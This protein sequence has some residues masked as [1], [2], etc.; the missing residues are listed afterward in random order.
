MTSYPSGTA[1]ERFYEVL[2]G[3]DEERVC[4]DIS[5]AS[6]HEQPRNFLTHF[7]SLAASRTAD[8]LLDPRLVLA[9]LLG[10]LGAPS[11]MIGMLVPIREAEALFAATRDRREYS[12]TAGTK[13][14]M[15]SRQCRAGF[16][17]DRDGGRRTL[18]RGG[19]RGMDH[20]GGAC[21]A[22]A[23]TQR[24][25]GLAQGRP[26]QDCLEIDPWH[27][28]RLCG[29]RVGG[30]DPGLRRAA[31]HGAARTVD[32][33]DRRGTLPGWSLVDRCGAG[34]RVASRGTGCDRRGA[35]C[36]RHGGRPV[37]AVA[38]R[39]AVAAVRGDPLPAAGHPAGAAFPGRAR[40]A[41]FGSARGGAGS[42]GLR[43]GAR[44]DLVQLCLG[45]ACRSVEPARAARRCGAGGGGP[46]GS[47][48]DRGWP[49]RWPWVVRCVDLRGASAGVCPDDRG[50][51]NA[52]RAQYA[53]GGHG[54]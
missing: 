40:G 4:F 2:I 38:R 42:F 11:F 6:C 9:W 13:M 49:W 34:V 17:R 19:R 28:G 5:E 45:P 23:R 41:C 1:C 39:S 50:A 37:R 36:A 10:A 20:P 46:G 8:G 26:R 15:G 53:C 35:Q 33:G 52:P 7:A 31:G 47:G 24:E 29:D 21:R 44:N 27:G 16:V 30:A 54:R 25:F 22:R 12:R 3:E 48:G 32:R 14:G 43:F 51:G 18:A